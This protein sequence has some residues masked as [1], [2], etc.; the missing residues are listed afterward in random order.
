MKL[1]LPLLN[2]ICV[3]QDYCIRWGIGCNL[4]HGGFYS[5]PDRYDPGTLQQH[6]WE[7]AMTID[8]YA[9]GY[10][11]D[12]NIEDVLSPQLLVEQVHLVNLGT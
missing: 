4:T 1:V 5:G 2:I 3:I 9:W 11:R 12:I 7:N 10:R 8:S 6:K